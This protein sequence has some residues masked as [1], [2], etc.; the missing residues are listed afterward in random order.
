MMA[1]RI[2]LVDDDDDFLMILRDRLRSVGYEVAVAQN[3]SDGIA[4]IRDGHPDA[5]PIMAGVLLDV[6]MP[7]ITGLEALR[8][9][10]ARFPSLP[11]IMM[12][13]FAPPLIVSEA[14]RLG[15]RGF[16]K[17]SE[18]LSDLLALC[19]STFGGPDVSIEKRRNV[20]NQ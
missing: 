18:D 7:V 15:A 20:E 2:L 13:S 10:S 17:K 9:M 5:P 8:E 11:V 14:R 19:V 16:F 4:A 12:S 1:R 3:G 6:Q